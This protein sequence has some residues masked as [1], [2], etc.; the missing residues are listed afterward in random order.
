[1]CKSSKNIV[2]HKLIHKLLISAHLK[3][4]YSQSK[5]NIAKA[6]KNFKSKR[7]KSRSKKLNF[8][9]KAFKALYNICYDVLIVCRLR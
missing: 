7:E 5:N 6:G 4:S 9:D 3:K 8:V 2:I 1:M